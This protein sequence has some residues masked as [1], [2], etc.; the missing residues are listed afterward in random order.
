M[1]FLAGIMLFSS[2]KEESAPAQGAEQEAGHGEEENPNMAELTEQQ[3][4]VA[5]ITLGKPEMRNLSNTLT[6][7]GELDVPPQNMASVSAP[8]GGFVKNTELLEGMRVKKG[9]LIVR[10]ENADFVTLQQDYL[11]ARSRLDFLELEYERQKELSEEQVTAA[12]TFQQVTAEFRSVR[13]Q[14]EGLAERLRII[15]VNPASLREGKISR[16]LPIFAPIDGYVTYINA[17][18]GQYVNPTDVLFRIADTDHLHV[19]LT[20]FEKDVAALKKG[21]QVRFALPGESGAEHEAT[22]YLIGREISEERTVQV[23]AHLKEEDKE[24]V[25]GM[26][27]QAQVSLG[28][29]QVLALPEAAVVQDAGNDFIFLYM[30]E[31]KEG[32]AVMKRFRM[33]PVESGA[34]EGGFVQVALPA[35]VDTANTN[36]VTK[37]AYSLLSR[38]RN[39]EEEGGHH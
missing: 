38:M 24:L 35:G 8:L 16:I 20:V 6:V 25:P 36:F 7:T 23:H 26:Y 32:D 15:G 4:R 1:F 31:E 14:V 19:E 34:A 2:C 28:G 33:V 22:I 12:K 30:G 5:G 9:Q 13:S 3:Y 10:I 18:V 39:S 37:G 11:E 21:Q 27:V 17:N 29:Q